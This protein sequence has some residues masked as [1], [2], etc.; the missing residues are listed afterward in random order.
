M[1]VYHAGTEIIPCPLVGVGREK[2]DFGRGFYVTTLQEQAKMWG[3]RISLRRK[4]GPVINCYEL[5]M[6]VVTS[7]YRFKKFLHYDKEWL[8]YIVDNCRGGNSWKAYD[9]IEGGVA[10]DRVIDT[11]EL[12]IGGY[13]TEEQAIGRLRLFAPNNQLCITSQSLCDECLHFVS[14]L[15]L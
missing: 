9:L 5:D 11:V 2:L 8:E 6:D 3:K 14:S 15:N 12:F 10:D 7:K 13:I 4:T 1:I